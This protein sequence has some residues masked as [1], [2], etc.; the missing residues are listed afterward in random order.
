[1]NKLDEENKKRFSAFRRLD[2][3]KFSYI[4]AVFANI[5]FL[6]R[7]AICWIAVF[8]FTTFIM[9]VSIGTSYDKPIGYTRTLVVYYMVKIPVRLHML[10]SGVIWANWSIKPDVDYSEYLGPDWKPSYEGAGI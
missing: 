5:L 2:L 3:E 6:P 1:L 10:M 4:S 7:F 8:V 9:I